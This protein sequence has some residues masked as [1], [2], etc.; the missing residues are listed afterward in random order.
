MNILMVAS[1]SLP[2]VKTGGLA[3]VVFSL[4]KELLPH[5]RVH[6]VLPMYESVAKQ[7]TSF[8]F[9]GSS[10][11][12][13][14][15][16]KQT[17]SF[18]YV[19]E[20]GIHYYFVAND[21]YFKRDRAYGYMDDGERFAFFTLAIRHLIKLISVAFHLIHIHDWQ[22]GML[23]A[24]IQEQER[25]HP[26]FLHTKFV[27][28][29]HNPAFQ[30]WLDSSYLSDFYNLPNALYE[31]GKVRFHNGISTLKSAIMYSDKIT[32]VSP[33][34]AKELLTE[35][36][37]YGL[38]HVLKFVEDKFSGIL[39]GIDD[40][41]SPDI[42]PMLH[43]NFKPSDH[44]EGKRKNKT[45]LFEQFKLTDPTRPLFGL[46]SRLTWQKG[47]DLVL[48]NL[49]WLIEQGGT[50]IILGS[51]EPSLEHELR[52]LA[53]RYPHH[54]LFY[55]GYAESLAHQIYAS[56]DY[57]LMPSLFEPCGISQMISLRY[58]TIPIVRKTGGLMDTIVPWL[59]QKPNLDCATGVMFE[60]YS[61]QAFQEALK[62]A[63]KLQAQP[64]FKD[65]LI[66]N[67]FKQ[68]HGWQVSAKHYHE[69][70]QSLFFDK[71]VKI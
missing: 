35:E 59:P 40:A 52:H 62:E 23:P 14:S 64:K 30:G 3:D 56:S 41:W 70:Y 29:I 22:A 53:D 7:S 57:F 63:L 20:A 10:E 21:Y 43:H 8:S 54:C 5:H 66:N 51:G 15:W 16:R 65:A 12:D 42:D 9:L 71:N 31:S 32:T 55:Y 24:L 46:V 19:V 17:A 39:N 2:F 34:H 33:T 58:G 68:H 45:F 50:V 11:V 18:Y 25:K 47:I 6:I 13:L 44:Q 49:S 37:G 28:T 1:E 48:A 67:G 36:G 69:L 4:S 60:T 38:H 27:L 61:A 26:L